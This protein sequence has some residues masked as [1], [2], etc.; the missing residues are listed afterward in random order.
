M[1]KTFSIPSRNSFLVLEL[2][3]LGVSALMTSIL[4][5]DRIVNGIEVRRKINKNVWT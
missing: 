3:I 2:K 5:E 1:S 4:F